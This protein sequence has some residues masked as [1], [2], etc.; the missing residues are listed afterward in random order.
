M[1]C[2][3][4]GIRQICWW[5]ESLASRVLENLQLCHCYLPTLL[6]KIRGKFVREVLKEIS[7]VDTH[8]LISLSLP[9]KSLYVSM[10]WMIFIFLF[11]LCWCR[12]AL[13]ITKFVHTEESC[14][15]TKR[16]PDLPLDGQQREIAWNLHVTSGSIYIDHMGA[17]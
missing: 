5:W 4:L 10:S 11:L 3:I 17:I 8:V 6:K 14:P 16:S 13:L 1:C 2:S 12:A 7:P 15:E 9:D